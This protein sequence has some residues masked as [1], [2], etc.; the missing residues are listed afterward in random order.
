MGIR[1]FIQGLGAAFNVLSVK[2][3]MPTS[4]NIGT[5]AQRLYARISKIAGRRLKDIAAAGNAGTKEALAE[6]IRSHQK[7]RTETSLGAAQVGK[8]P[9]GGSAGIAHQLKYNVLQDW[10][11]RVF[12]DPLALPYALAIERFCPE[13]SGE[14]VSDDITEFGDALENW[15]IS[16]TAKVPEPPINAPDDGCELLIREEVI[17]AREVFR[18]CSF[19]GDYGLSYTT[20]MSG[21]KNIDIETNFWRVLQDGLHAIQKDHIA[22]KKPDFFTL[23]RKVCPIAQPIHLRTF[24]NW[25]QQYDDMQEMRKQVDDSAEIAKIFNHN[26]HKPL[27][28][29]SEMR[30]SE[31]QFKRLDKS[32]SGLIKAEDIAAYLGLDDLTAQEVFQGYDVN[33][34]GLVDKREFLRLMCPADCRMPE[35]AGSERDIFGKLVASKVS[36]IQRALLETEALFDGNAGDH[37]KQV[38]DMPASCLPEVSEEVWKQWNDLFDR[39]DKNGDNRVDVADLMSSGILSKDVSEFLASNIEA[40]DASGFSRDSL[41][42][43]LLEVNKVRRPNFSV[44]R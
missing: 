20:I 27:W 7:K 42:E 9:T 15:Y 5:I 14:D 24:A 6:A 38:M 8:T 41:L 2:D 4:E 29:E 18:Y 23:L 35:M 13:R 19:K 30:E 10:C 34:D 40:A 11:F 39:L 28:A 26:D 32:R 43:A 36:N 33:S 1:S 22:G 21:L 12:K 25:C 37:R 3:V 31:E 44:G 17:T 16:H